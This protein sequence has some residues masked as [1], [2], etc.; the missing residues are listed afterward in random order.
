M[1][2]FFSTT[3]GDDERIDRSRKM[4]IDWLPQLNLPE[5]YGYVSFMAYVSYGTTILDI[6]QSCSEGL[7]DTSDS[8]EDIS[9]NP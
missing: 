9:T 3:P 1:R 8:S 6:Y 5:L 4:M 7:Y 2:P